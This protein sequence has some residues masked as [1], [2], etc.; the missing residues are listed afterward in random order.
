[1]Q[2]GSMSITATIGSRL[3]RVRMRPLPN[4]IIVIA[5]LTLLAFVLIAILAPVIAPHG[6]TEQSLLNRLK[7]PGTPGFPLGTD[8][9]GRDVLSR[10]IYGAQLSLAVGFA[11]MLLT[12]IVGVAIGLISGYV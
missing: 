4:A 8:Q 7:P 3:D 12:A 2:G 5:W 6:P 9:L 11:V 10:L 1:P